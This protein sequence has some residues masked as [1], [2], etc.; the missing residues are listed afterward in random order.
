MPSLEEV[1]P[2]WHFK[3]P[4]LTRASST[5]LMEKFESYLSAGDF[6]GADMA[7]KFLQMGFT[8]ARPYANYKGGR[9]YK[10]DEDSTLLP[11]GTGSSEKAE[12]AVIF[13]GVWRQA[14]AHPLYAAM[15]T[16]W[17]QERG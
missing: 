7:L 9:R 8:R 10:A 4:D 5:A 17:K 1:W 15:K 6:V 14:E 13:H 16:R 11:R 12:S 2:I 3:T